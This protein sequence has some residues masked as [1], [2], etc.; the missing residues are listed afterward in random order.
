MEVTSFN[1]SFCCYNYCASSIILYNC[2][3][4]GPKC[5]ICSDGYF[6][7]PTGKN[8]PVSN[9]KSCDCNSNVD[10]NAIGNCNRTTGECLKCIY[11]T[12]G[13]QCDQCLP[14]T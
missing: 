10:A 1:L 2:I 9:C 7:D 6:G 8:G 12:G 13:S 3:F 14:G 5:D 11:N 4:S